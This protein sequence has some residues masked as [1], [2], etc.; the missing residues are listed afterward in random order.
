[1]KYFLLGIISTLIIISLVAA[2]DKDGKK[3]KVKDDSIV[4]DSTQIN[5]YL[6]DAGL[7]LAKKNGKHILVNFT[8]KWCGYCKRMEKETFSNAEIIKYINTN[9]VSIKVDG[10]SPNE[11]NINGYKITEQ[12]LAR[13]EYQITGY[14]TFWFLQSNGER[15]GPAPGYWPSNRFFDILS[16]VKDDLHKK[17]T[18]D[19]YVKSGGRKRQN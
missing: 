16:F 7:K 11:L 12:N 18:F 3:P 5:W 9:F 4:I 2:Q 8:A 10:D 17:M 15:I 1:M 13:S 19:E 14:P 6:Y